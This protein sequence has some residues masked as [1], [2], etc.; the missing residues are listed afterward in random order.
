MRRPYFGLGFASKAL[1]I[2]VSA[3]KIALSFENDTPVLV[4]PSTSIVH[5]HPDGLAVCTT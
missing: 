1:S 4:R 5:I 3:L 2:A